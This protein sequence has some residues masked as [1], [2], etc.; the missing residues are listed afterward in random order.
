MGSSNEHAPACLEANASF[1]NVP[2]A[3]AA[4]GC[5]WVAVDHDAAVELVRRTRAAQG[6]PARI[7]DRA[8]RARVL[9]LLAGA[10]SLARA[11]HHVAWN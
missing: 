1:R 9:D 6:L 5:R 2:I 11:G 4:G 10:M 3:D 8:A 7:E